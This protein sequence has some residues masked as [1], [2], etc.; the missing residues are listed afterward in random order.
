M[1]LNLWLGWKT[2]K[3]ANFCWEIIERLRHFNTQE[4]LNITIFAQYIEYLKQAH[5][6][7]MMEEPWPRNQNVLGLAFSLLSN[8][9][10]V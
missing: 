5:F 4:V 1:D 7:G 10:S 9:K 2:G 6:L 8:L 3:Q